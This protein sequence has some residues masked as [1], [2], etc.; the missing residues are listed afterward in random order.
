[1]LMWIPDLYCGS[2]RALKADSEC[3][4]SGLRNDCGIDEFIGITDI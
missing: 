2:S 4:Q 1:M 3:V